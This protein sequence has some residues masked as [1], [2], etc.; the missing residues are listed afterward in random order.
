MMTLMMYYLLLYYFGAI[1]SGKVSSVLAV[2]LF[3]CFHQYSIV[4]M[5]PSPITYIQCRITD[6]NIAT[7]FYGNCKYCV[8]Y[9]AF[10]ARVA[11]S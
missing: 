5:I 2:A 3:V 1:V 6:N 7:F 11:N 10:N 9:N 8:L 4:N